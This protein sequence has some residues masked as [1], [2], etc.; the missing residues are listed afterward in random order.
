MRFLVNLRTKIYH[1]KR[2]TSKVCCLEKAEDLVEAATITRSMLKEYIYCK[3]C[4]SMERKEL[5]AVH[6]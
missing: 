1:D 4:A 2:F 6:G 3:H 5:G